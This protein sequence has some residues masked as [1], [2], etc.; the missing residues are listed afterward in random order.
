MPSYVGVE[1]RF[2]E[3]GGGGRI[4]DGHVDVPPDGGGNEAAVSSGR[5]RV[6]SEGATGV[7]QLGDRLRLGK[8]EGLPVEN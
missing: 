1:H 3:V 5:P 6:P 7:K 2:G 8:D 4:A